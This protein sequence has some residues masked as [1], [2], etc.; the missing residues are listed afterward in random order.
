[1]LRIDYV[2]D[3]R[4]PP[5]YPDSKPKYQDLMENLKCSPLNFYGETKLNGERAALAANPE[6]AISLRVPILYTLPR[7]CPSDI[8]MEKARTTS[9]PSTS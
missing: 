1:M 2:F 9:Q 6:S 8:D 3:G 7:Y 5:Y 4:N